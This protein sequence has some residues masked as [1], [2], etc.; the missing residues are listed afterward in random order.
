MV[1]LAVVVEVEEGYS[2]D[3]MEVAQ[4]GFQ[5]GP[6][7]TRAGSRSYVQGEK[8]EHDPLYMVVVDNKVVVLWGR[9]VEEW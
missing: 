4:A 3:G 9:Q 5:E 6:R 8:T 7:L 2:Q 1:G